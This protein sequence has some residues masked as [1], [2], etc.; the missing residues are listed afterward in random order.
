MRTLDEMEEITP[1]ILITPPP[2]GT[3]CYDGSWLGYQEPAKVTS[4]RCR[5]WTGTTCTKIDSVDETKWCDGCK[6]FMDSCNARFKPQTPS[7]VFLDAERRMES[8]DWGCSKFNGVRISCTC[9]V[10][11]LDREKH[12]SL[13][14][15]Y[16]T[17]KQFTHRGKEGD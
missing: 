13:C 17:R 2:A 15:V 12:L 10:L 1:E 11:S 9:G 3:V 8:V 16:I 14:M 5:K 6:A 7:Q 4:F